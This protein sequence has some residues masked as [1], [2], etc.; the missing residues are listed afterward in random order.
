[1]S[2]DVNASTHSGIESS[3]LSR[4]RQELRHSVGTSKGAIAGITA[5]VPIRAKSIPKP[6][7][8]AFDLADSTRTSFTFCNVLTAGAA[9]LSSTVPDAGIKE[10][11]DRLQGEDGNH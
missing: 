10:A 7:I 3:A 6:T 9:I 11:V 2:P 4:Q 1:M 5:A 8:P